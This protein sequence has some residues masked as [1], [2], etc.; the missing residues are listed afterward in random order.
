MN[1]Y[2]FSTFIK[3]FHKLTIKAAQSYLYRFSYLAVHCFLHSIGNVG[4][5]EYHLPAPSPPSQGLKHIP[6]SQNRPTPKRQ[7]RHTTLHLKLRVRAELERKAKEQN[8]SISATGAAFLEWALQQSMYAQNAALLETIIAKSI[9]K[10]IRSYSNRF[11][12]LLVR[13]L[14]ASEQAR[15]YAINILGRLPGMTDTELNDIKYGA[16]NTARANITRVT[17]QMKT[18]IEAVQQ[19]L[20]EAEKGGMGNA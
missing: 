3:S 1:E 20:E 2:T 11:A 17:P 13:S 16:N 15:S 4:F 5:M 8:L 9:G 18:L 14:F 6:R 19:W 12:V 7:T 10:H